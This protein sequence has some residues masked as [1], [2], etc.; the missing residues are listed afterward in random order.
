MKKVFCMKCGTEIHVEDDQTVATC[1][2][3]AAAFSLTQNITVNTNSNVSD[4]VVNEINQDINKNGVGKIRVFALTCDSCGGQVT[5]K[6]GQKIAMCQH[7]GNTIAVDDGTRRIEIVNEAQKLQNAIDREELEKKKAAHE[8]FEK[9]YAAQK[10]RRNIWRIF[11][12]LTA[13]IF[14]ALIVLTGY[15][16]YDSDAGGL[17]PKLVLGIMAY[18]LFVPIIIV[19]VRPFLPRNEDDRSD[20]SKVKS[21]FLTWLL[22]I[23]VLVLAGITIGAVLAFRG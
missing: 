9:T 14:Y 8:A 12:A 17:V 23:G 20:T 11:Y 6:E 3:C 2:N 22:Y 19:A 16:G 15:L 4:A 10:S 21:M 13:V 5:V 7:C 18:F 1:P